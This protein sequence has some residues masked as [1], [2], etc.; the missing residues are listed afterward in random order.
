MVLFLVEGLD[1]RGQQHIRQSHHQ[2]KAE[3]PK[4]EPCQPEQTAALGK[5]EPGKD[6]DT[7]K[8]GDHHRRGGAA[9]HKGDAAGAQKV[10]NK[11]LRPHGL[12][13]PPGL[14]QRHIVQPQSRVGQVGVSHTAA[15]RRA[16]HIV[17]KQEGGNIKHRADGPEGEHKPP[18]R[19][20]RPIPGGKGL[21]LV[22]VIPGQNDAQRIVQQIQQQKLQRGHRQ[23]G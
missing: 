14:E 8:G 20:P 10:Q 17:Q 9:L 7:R 13:E 12:Q 23:E 15:E 5:G 19:P 18:Q 6:H 16:Q 1:H 21:L 22:H 3:V 11:H 4:R 2:Q